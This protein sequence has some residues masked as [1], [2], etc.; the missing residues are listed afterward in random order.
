MQ[1][2][3]CLVD[4]THMFLKYMCNVLLKPQERGKGNHFYFEGIFEMWGHKADEK[5]TSLILIMSN[6]CIIQ[7]IEI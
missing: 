1:I 5:I 2:R 3:D 6:K 4:C 7:K